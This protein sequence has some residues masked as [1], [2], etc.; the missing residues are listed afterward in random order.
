[1]LFI[2]CSG[3]SVS[4]SG[5]LMES[6]GLE[7]D[8]DTKCSLAAPTSAEKCT[9]EGCESWALKERGGG[10]EGGGGREGGTRFGWLACRADDFFPEGGD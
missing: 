7:V 2:R 5:I 4:G 6:C 8:L 10:F 1:M 3:G 9:P